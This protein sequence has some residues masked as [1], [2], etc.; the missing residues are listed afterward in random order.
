MDSA[1]N[2]LTML[3]QGIDKIKNRPGSL[4]VQTGRGLVEEQKQLGLGSQFN[5]N[6]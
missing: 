5:T 1:K 3:S 4:T 2:G 6:G